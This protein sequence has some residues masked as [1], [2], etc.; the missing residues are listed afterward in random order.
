MQPKEKEGQSV[1]E[2]A[3]ETIGIRLSGKTADRLS[4]HDWSVCQS[5]GASIWS[6]LFLSFYPH[7]L[8]LLLLSC[9]S[10]LLS[11]TPFPGAPRPTLGSLLLAHFP[12]ERGPT[13]KKTSLIR[14]AEWQSRLPVVRPVHMDRPARPPPRD[15][16]QSLSCRYNPCMKGRFRRSRFHCRAHGRVVFSRRFPIRRPWHAA[17]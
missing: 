8:S 16:R 3:R 10:F 7:L 13:S 4:T 15:N 11:R 12:I 1:R 9:L 17:F 6:C 2:R 5:G 14:M